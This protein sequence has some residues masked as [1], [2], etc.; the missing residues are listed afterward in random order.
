MT[1]L[2]TYYE[3]TVARNFTRIILEITDR[4]SIKD[5]LDN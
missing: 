2:F 1:W 3:L 5:K 4:N